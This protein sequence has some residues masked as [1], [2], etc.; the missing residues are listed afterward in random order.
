MVQLSKNSILET[1]R[2]KKFIFPILARFPLLPDSVIDRFY[3]N[4]ILFVYQME[5]QC[6]EGYATNYE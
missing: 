6:K 4:I 5:L 2:L 3:C 1:N